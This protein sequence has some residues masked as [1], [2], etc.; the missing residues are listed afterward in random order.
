MSAAVGS[1]ANG[2]TT[3]PGEVKH[4]GTRFLCVIEL[5]LK[6]ARTVPLITEKISTYG[7]QHIFLQS[8]RTNAFSPHP[9][10]H[11]HIPNASIKITAKVYSEYLYVGLFHIR[12]TYALYLTLPYRVQIE[13]Y[14]CEKKKDGGKACVPQNGLTCFE[15]SLFHTDELSWGNRVASSHL[16]KTRSSTS[17]TK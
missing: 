4:K 13:R 10:T 9:H 15:D 17:S 8:I 16:K 12:T 5:V 3:A 6:S 14:D 1:R 7:R 11:T 2:W